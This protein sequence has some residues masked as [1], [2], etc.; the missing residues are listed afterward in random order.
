MTRE[1]ALQAVEVGIVQAQRLAESG[2]HLVAA[3]EMGIGN[4]TTSAAVASVLLGV[5]P[6]KIVG[7]GAGLDDAA[8]E[9]KRSVVAR[10]IEVNAPNADD[11][12]DVLAKLG[13]L[14]IA[15]MCGFYLGAAANRL[16][17]V[18][19]GVISCVAALLAVSLEPKAKGYLVASHTSSEP[20]ARL[21]LDELGLNAPLE[22][23][24]HLGE[25][26]GA[27]AY[28]PVLDS[29]LAVYRSGRSFE[30]TGIAAYEHLGS[31]Q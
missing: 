6:A 8:L 22:A 28:L 3:G 13:G 18:L 29:A 10:A 30:E 26:A 21:L 11:P 14:D 23:D 1:E 5:E 27:M 16:P 9:K 4:T 12:V 20:A 17:V 7:R 15:A 2:V 31:G 25:G 19:D 24:M